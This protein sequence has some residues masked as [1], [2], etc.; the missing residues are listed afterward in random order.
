MASFIQ[1]LAVPEYLN[2]RHAE[3]A[4]GISQSSVWNGNRKRGSGAASDAWR[5]IL[6]ILDE[7]DPFPFSA[8]WSP[9]NLSPA[10]RSF[11]DL[12]TKMRSQL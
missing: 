6:P 4:L 9:H 5:Q 11:L 1:I 3:N 2:F 7:P 8:I 10:L 12:A